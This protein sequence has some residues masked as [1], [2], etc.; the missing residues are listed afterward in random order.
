MRAERKAEPVTEGFDSAA[1]EGYWAGE[2]HN[3][4]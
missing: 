1:A 2:L 3:Q 4:G